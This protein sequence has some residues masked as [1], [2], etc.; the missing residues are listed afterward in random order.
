MAGGLFIQGPGVL[1][2]GDGATYQA[3]DG[4]GMIYSTGI[5]WNSS[6]ED[7]VILDGATG[8]AK[9]FKAGKSTLIA[10]RE[11][12][13]S[14]NPSTAFFDVTVLARVPNLKGMTGPEAL[15]LISEKG[16][17][18]TVHNPMPQGKVAA[19]TP[20]PGT[21]ISADTMVSITLAEESSDPDRNI[22]PEDSVFST[23][24][25][26][27]LPTR[28]PS[29]FSTSGGESNSSHPDDDCAGL[30]SD[31]YAALTA[32]DAVWAESLLNRSAHCGFHTEAVAAFNAL[33]DQKK[34]DS[35]D[36]GNTRCDTLYHHYTAALNSGDIQS[37]QDII[38]QAPD[39]P[40][41]QTARTHIDEL[42]RIDACNGFMQQFQAY[43]Q[44]RQT[45]AARNVLDQARQNGCI[46]HQ[47][48]LDALQAA[49]SHDKQRSVDFFN[50]FQQMMQ[51]MPVPNRP[52]AQPPSNSPPPAP[53]R[54]E[55]RTPV[56]CQT[57][58]V[59]EETK[60]INTTDGRHSLCKGKTGRVYP[61]WE[62]S[63]G[64]PYYIICE[65]QTVCLKYEKRC[66]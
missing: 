45:Q 17:T 25:G 16:L 63:P 46:L 28:N 30:E 43:L 29:E 57:V 24:G 1:L 64:N 53:S 60:I 9:A 51:N 36:R 5:T 27:G 50:T 4:A 37:A 20:A 19:Q 10:H 39:C 54:P 8:S 22:R 14:Q 52:P 42:N 15:G 59:R 12:L 38:L 33:S 3:V 2:S 11:Y 32:K 48:A 26:N 34:R 55:T 7:V 41:Y 13:G 58:C 61:G 66:R 21:V 47:S 65:K 62:A 44:N 6:V 49:E 40:F 18:G 23:T 31:V 35:L 56:D